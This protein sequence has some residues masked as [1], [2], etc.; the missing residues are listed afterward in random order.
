M[1]RAKYIS[2]SELR[3]GI[4]VIA[5][6]ILLAATILYI[7]R[8]QGIFA[9]TYS[10]KVYMER[11]NGL[12]T[13]AP[14]WLSGV[15]VGSVQD[16]RFRDKVKLKEIEVVLE[17]DKQVQQRIRKDSVARIGTL[18]LLGDK[19]VAITQGS[20]TESAIPEGGML[21]GANPVDFEELISD[22]STAIDD[23]VITLENARDITNKINSGTGTL[24]LLVN[25]PDLIEETQVLIRDT[26]GLIDKIQNGD[27]TL[28]RLLNDEKLYTGM[29]Q[30]LWSSDTLANHIRTQE[31]TLG[32]LIYDPSLYDNLTGLTERFDSLLQKV[33]SGEGTAG[34]LLADEA[35]Y[36]ELK[37]LSESTRSLVDDIKRNPARYINIKIF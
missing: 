2:W 31:G 14:V 13:G 33:E 25:K 32:K 8:Q 34:K 17:I 7:G 11:I 3:V 26:R 22:A 10:L 30:L 9:E 18:G 16:I 15:S 6:F 5:S 20:S 24:G 1:R 36:E 37:L 23:L 21:Q 35:L 28:A 29:S 12:Q 19:Y 4:L 27:G